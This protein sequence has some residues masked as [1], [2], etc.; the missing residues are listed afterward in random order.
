MEIE[1]DEGLISLYYGFIMNRNETLEYCIDV[2]E[3][4]ETIIIKR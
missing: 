2:Y 1:V 4:I 3:R